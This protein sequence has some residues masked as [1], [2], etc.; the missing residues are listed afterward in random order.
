M[1]GGNVT[2][3]GTLGA[4]NFSGTSSGT[5]T[6]DQTNISGNAATVTMNGGRTDATAYQVVWGVP[7]S[8]PMYGCSAVTIQS[9]TGTLTATNLTGTLKQRYSSTGTRMWNPP[10]GTLTTVASSQTGALTITM[11]KMTDV[12]MSFWVDVYDYAGNT[13]F[14]V[15]VSGYPYSS[16]GIWSNTSAMILGAVSRQFTVRF[17]GSTDNTKSI[18]YIGETGTVWNY[19]QVQVRDVLIGYNALTANVDGIDWAISYST[20]FL[21]VT[22]SRTDV[23]PYASNANTLGGYSASG[24][25]GANTVVIR[26]VNGYIYANYINSNVSETENPTINSF[27][28][29]N[30]DG[31]LRKSSVAHVKSQLGLGSMAYAATSS[32]VAKSGDTMT[33]TLTMSIGSGSGNSGTNG[34]YINQ[35]VLDNTYQYAMFMYENGGQATGYQCIGWYNGNQSYYKARMYTQVGGS[36]ANT[37]FYLDV[38]D[39]S[40]AL[41][42]RL[43]FDNGSA[44]FSGDVVAY[45]SD[46]RLKEN[47]TPIS[48]SLNKIKQIAGVYFD[49]KDKVEGTSFVPA[50]KHDVGVIAQDVQKILPEVVTLAPFDTDAN[51][52]SKS[53][54]N[55]LTVKYDKLVPLLIEAIKE[56]SSE[57]SE[58]KA[59]LEL[60]ESKLKD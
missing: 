24:T 10:G 42:T 15:F 22:V 54:E 30:G 13:T 43:Y 44:Y 47:V 23:L 60:I 50:Q 55:Y 17:G 26:D 12:M 25:V 6:G 20:S 11:P 16:A 7:G 33:S 57:N 29:S 31:W 51:G 46:K 14:S 4:S 21:N 28:T 39:N 38:A 45:S 9:S 1:D 35:A 3:T 40:R 37:R 48:D 59:R 2:A 8:T 53:G 41:A 58:L 5:N 32:Y 56:L 36:Y 18:V 27:Y 34:I 49:W 19:P 52:G